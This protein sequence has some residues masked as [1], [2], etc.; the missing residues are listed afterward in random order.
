MFGTTLIDAVRRWRRGVETR[1]AL[2]VL[3]DARLADIGIRRDDIDDVAA[4]R[5][6]RGR[7]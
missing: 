3:S 7:A 4:G 2:H 5:C 1:R 6:R